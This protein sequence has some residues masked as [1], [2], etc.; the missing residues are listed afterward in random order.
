MAGPVRRRRTASRH[1]ESELWEPHRTGLPY[2]EP[3]DPV[4]AGAAAIKALAEAL[5]VSPLDG[6]FATVAPRL[7]SPAGSVV[8]DVAVPAKSYASRIFISGFLVAAADGG[9]LDVGATINI[10]P[11]ATIATPVTKSLAANVYVYI[12]VTFSWTVPANVAPSFNVSC[13]LPFAVSGGLYAGANLTWQR[14][15]T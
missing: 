3:T 14:Y 8:L 9:A 1:E 13:Y 12:P 5:S 6:A 10:T 4:A 15:R 11:A 2:P 7:L